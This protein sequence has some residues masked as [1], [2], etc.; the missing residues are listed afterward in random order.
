MMAL[1][2]AKPKHRVRVVARRWHS[3]PMRSSSIAAISL[4]ITLIASACGGPAGPSLNP[5]EPLT[6]PPASPAEQSSSMSSEEAAT[7]DAPRTNTTSDIGD[8][9]GAGPPSPQPLAQTVSMRTRLGHDRAAYTQ[10]LLFHDGRLYESRGRY[11][12]SALTEIDP[13][14]GEVLRQAVVDPDY[15]AEGLALVDNRLIQLTWQAGV[16]L[17]YDLESFDLIGQYTYSGE[18]WGLCYDGRDLWMSDGSSTLTRRDPV[19]F[20]AIERID[21]TLNG[22]PLDQLNELECFDGLVWANVWKTNQFVAIDPSTGDVVS[23]IDARGLLSRDERDAGA[24][25]L[26]GI[27]YDRDRDVL[28]LTGKW[29]PA[30]FEVDLVP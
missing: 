30:M 20:E 18:G 25:V 4:A 24:E 16:A 14:T 15:F 5:V 29:W 19:G 8:D 7:S 6:L 1:H 10:G 26:N 9:A 11:G 23:V 12:K 2:T 28:V 21:V 17:V 22:G 13:T 3:G 27:A